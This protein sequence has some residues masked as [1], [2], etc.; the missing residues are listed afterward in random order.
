MKRAD[1]DDRLDY[2]AER[3]GYQQQRKGAKLNPDWVGW[4]MGVPI[5]WESLEPLP[6]ENFNEWLDCQRDGT[7]WDEDRGLPRVDVDIKDRASR[8]KAL[9]NGIVPQCIGLFINQLIKER[10]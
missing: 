2:T 3:E 8:L 4:L 6:P 10:G 9:G 1:T 5:G 7:W